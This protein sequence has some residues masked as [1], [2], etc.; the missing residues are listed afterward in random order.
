MKGLMFAG[1]ITMAF[2]AAAED[3][4][5]P[6]DFDAN[7]EAHVADVLATCT[8][9]EASDAGTVVPRALTSVASAG[10]GSEANP[11]EPRTFTWGVSNAI[12]FDSL[13][14]GFLLFLR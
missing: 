2:A 13:F 11:F 14:P 12:D 8:T 4:A 10:Y 6:A 3:P 1:I 7:V 5:W 9:S